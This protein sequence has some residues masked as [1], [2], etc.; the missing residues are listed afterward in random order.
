VNCNNYYIYF[1]SNGKFYF[2][3]YD[4][5]NTVG[6][7]YMIDAGKQNPLHWG[8][9]IKNPLIAKILTIDNYKKQYI[10]YLKALVS[11]S[12]GLMDYTS[13]TT[14]IRAM[15]AMISSSVSNDTGEDMTISDNPASWGNYSNYRIL[16]SNPSTNF[17]KVKA[18]VID[19]LER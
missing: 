16:D 19:A 7:S 3:P 5:D 17:F 15:Q 10:K 11:S 6:T 1:N 9:D 18:A 2:I 12:N 4:L 14:R 8:D 13:A